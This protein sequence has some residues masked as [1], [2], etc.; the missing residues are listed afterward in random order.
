[1]RENVRLF[2]ES[3]HFVSHWLELN[4]ESCPPMD[5]ISFRFPCGNDQLD[6]IVDYQHRVILWFLPFV[7]KDRQAKKDRG[8]VAYGV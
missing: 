1:M 4:A 2:L 6:G 8:L 5:N 7:G 3:G